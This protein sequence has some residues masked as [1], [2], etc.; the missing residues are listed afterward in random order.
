MTLVLPAQGHPRCRSGLDSCDPG[1]VSS[2]S[3][4]RRPAAVGRVGAAG[5]P[6]SGRSHLAGGRP[7]TLSGC[8]E[9]MAIDSSDAGTAAKAAADRDPAVDETELTGIDLTP[10]GIPRLT[11]R[12][13]GSIV[14]GVAAGI[15]DHLRRP[16]ALGPSGI[17]ADGGDG[18][19]RRAGLR[20]AVDLRPARAGPEAERDGAPGPHRARAAAGVGIAALGIALMIAATAL[21]IGKVL[22]L[23]ARAARAGRARRRLHL[24]RGRRRPPRALAQ[25]RSRHRRP[26]PGHGLAG[27]RRCRAG[28]RRAVGVRARPT[29]LHRGAVRA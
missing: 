15:A 1:G 21:G 12:R 17:C 9:T 3:S 4:A 14:G 2:H 13:D 10:D 5:R 19:G 11:R 25:D 16:G 29:R 7:S 22:G 26:E 24:A 23:G 18:R 27:R 6:G 28:G 20:A 8:R